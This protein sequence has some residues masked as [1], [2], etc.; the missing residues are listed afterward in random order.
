MRLRMMTED[1]Y[2]YL[3]SYTD[4][5][6]AYGHYEPVASWVHVSEADA[7][8]LIPG[9][10]KCRGGLAPYNV[11]HQPEGLRA[12]DVGFRPTIEVPRD[13]FPLELQRKIVAVGAL[14]MNGEPVVVP[15]GEVKDDITA[16]QQGA[17]LS[18]NTTTDVDPAYLVTGLLNGNTVYVDRC[19]LNYI[20]YK[21]IEA[22]IQ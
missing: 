18:F 2:L 1:E 5:S 13:M 3:L 12:R 7:S 4:K 6:N 15:S 14:C 21:D 11:A 16:Y 10:R 19:L 8:S 9:Y 17:S 20:S 22:A